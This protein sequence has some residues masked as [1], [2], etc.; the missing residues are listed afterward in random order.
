MNP[1]PDIY[2]ALAPHYREY[3]RGKSAYL[4]AVDRFIL[5]NVPAGASSLLD[6]GAGDGVRGMALAR[7][8]KAKR[9]VLCETSRNMAA[10]C[11][12]LAP[13]A[14]WEVPAEQ[15]PESSVRFDVASSA[16][17]SQPSSAQ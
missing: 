11:R 6:V 8:L 2:D 1:S 9:V 14:V 17:G 7:A 13:D 3:S 16:L 12:T 4:D 10:R 5:D 15:L